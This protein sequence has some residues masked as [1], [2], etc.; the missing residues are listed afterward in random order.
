M[1]TYGSSDN[2]LESPR[3]A[4][5]PAT[6]HLVTSTLPAPP[7]PRLRA[8]RYEPEPDEPPVRVALPLPPVAAP[9]ADLPGDDGVGHRA[10]QVL[11]LALEVL[12]GRRPA[13]HLAGQLAPAALRYLRAA[14][15]RRPPGSAPG[16]LTSLRLCR[17]HPRAAEVA[18]VYRLDGRAR[19]LAARF[20]R[21]GDDP[22]DW[23]C[24]VLRLV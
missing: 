9:P 4:P 15:A 21:C 17:P 11:R 1:A 19:A 24:V 20:E 22:G 16:R 14:E 2:G 7:V 5:V 8:M 23:R 12:G 10:Q 3:G 13:A 18:A 6:L